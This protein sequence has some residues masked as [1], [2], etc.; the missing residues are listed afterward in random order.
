MKTSSKIPLRMVSRLS[1]KLAKGLQIL[2]R[3]LGYAVVF[4]L[5]VAGAFCLC[6]PFRSASG[7]NGA[8]VVLMMFYAFVQLLFLV[9]PSISLHSLECW[10]GVFEKKTNKLD[11]FFHSLSLSLSLSLAIPLSRAHFPSKAFFPYGQLHNGMPE[12]WVPAS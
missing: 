9:A 7:K 10:F 3:H 1:P 8:F 5:C 11:V 4:L 2:L 6:S 12:D